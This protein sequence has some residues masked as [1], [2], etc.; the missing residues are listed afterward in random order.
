MRS[1][2]LGLHL[3]VEKLQAQADE[4]ATALAESQGSAQQAA[5]ERSQAE[6][7]GRAD[8]K[9]CLEELHQK[10]TMSGAYDHRCELAASCC[11]VSL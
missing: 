5:A 7:K 10:H 8:M 9:V 4:S 3:Q 2:K 6:A 11:S 1:E